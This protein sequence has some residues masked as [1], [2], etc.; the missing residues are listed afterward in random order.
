MERSILSLVRCAAIVLAV[1]LASTRASAQVL[2]VELRDSLSA[3][4]VSGVLVTALDSTGQRRADGLSGEGGVVTL[5]LPSAGTW[6]ITVRR[7]GVRPR[8][9][10]GVRVLDGSS[11]VLVLNVASMQQ[12]LPPVRVTA[13]GSSCGREPDADTRVGRLWEQITLALRAATISQRDKGALPPLLVTERRNDL[14]ATLEER[15]SVVTRQTTGSG[16]LVAADDPETLATLGYVREEAD[17]SRAYFAPDEV[18]LLS[19]SFLA[20]HC[21]STPK[22]DANALLAE[23]RFKPV[24]GRKVADVE[25]TAFVDVNTGE[26]RRI[27]YSYVASRKLIPVF[28]EH[29]GGEVQ[30]RR[31]ANGQWIVNKWFIRMPI[32]GQ[33]VTSQRLV[34]TGYHEVAGLVQ[35]MRQLGPAAAP[36]P[37]H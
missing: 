15:N 25:G 34:V 11:Q 26:L 27:T 28:A 32:F 37:P 35:D 21:F 23:L 1:L 17:D 5:R 20:T 29:A 7:I 9:I 14:S 31:L 3:A 19:D 22:K 8:A 18:V 12:L 10:P 4:P 24:R 2:R 36:R 13:D 33:S 16:R 6:T 30:V